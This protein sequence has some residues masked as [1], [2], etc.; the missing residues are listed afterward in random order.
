MSNDQTSTHLLKD[1]LLYIYEKIEKNK[2][3]NSFLDALHVLLVW[4]IVFIL[5]EH[6]GY[7]PI[8]IKRGS[9]I[10][11]IVL[12]G[13]VYWKRRQDVE[14]SNFIDFYRTFSSVS[15]LKELGYA[16][17]L[18][19]NTV[20]HPKLIEAAIFKNLELVKL[21]KFNSKLDEFY[22]SNPYTKSLAKKKVFLLLLMGVAVLI[23]LNLNDATTRYFTFYQDF[24]K[25]NPYSF[26]ITPGNSTLEQG[27]PFKVTIEF[28]NDLIPNEVSLFLKTS[29]EQEFRKRGLDGQSNIFISSTIDLNT[30]ILYYLEMDGFKTEVFEVNIQLRPRLTEFNLTIIPPRYTRLD[31]SFYKYP[32][33]QVQGIQGSEMLLFG[34]ANKP[35]K[36][37]V[38]KNKEYK[39]D[40]FI[41]D[42]LEFSFVSSLIE[43]DTVQ[44]KLEDEAGL[45]NLNP[46]Q[47][48]VFPIKDEHPIAEILEPK[49]SFEKI[50]PKTITIRYRTSD[51]FGITKTTLVYELK[52]AFIEQ[53]VSNTIEF[54]SNKNGILQTFS[55]DI[56]SLKLKPKDELIF[57]IETTDNDGFNGYK[58]ARSVSITLSV[59]SLVDYFD[60]IN[61]QEEQIQ[62]DLENVSESFE[63]M[64]K[65]YEMFEEQMRV[66]PVVDYKDI[67]QLEEVKERQE[68][69]KEQLEKLNAKFEE[70]KEE[71]QESN[72]LSEE[73]LE[74]Y[75]ELQKLLDEIDDPAF[76]DALQEL[77]ENL[78]S[79][80]LEQ[81]RQAMQ[82]TEFNEQ[83][84][85]E[86]IER[87]VELFKKLKLNADLE[88][89]ATS[90]ED[91]ARQE[92]KQRINEEESS[93]EK[94]EDESL[95]EQTK[96]VEKN[97]EKLDENTSLNTKSIIDELQ[98]QSKKKLDDIKKALEKRLEEMNNE[99][100]DSDSSNQK[101]DDKNNGGK[102]GDK[103]KDSGPQ[104]QQEP[105]LKEQFQ[106]LAQITRNAMSQM[107]QEQ[108]NVNIAGLQYILFSLLNLSLEQEE[109]SIYTSSTKSRSKAY[110]E[111]AR[112]QKNVENIFLSLSDSLF[113]LSKDIPPFSNQI[114]EDK[115]EVERLVEESLTQI[116]ERNQNRASVATRQALGG[117]NKIS[118][119]IAG[120]LEQLQNQNSGQGGSG[121]GMSMQQMI[122][123]MQQMGKNQQQINQQIQ[124][125][126]NDIQGERLSQDQMERLDQLSQQQNK[127]R[128][129]LQDIQQN[130][131]GVDGDKLGSELERMIEQME[132]TINDLR[133]GAVD[134]TLIWRQQNILSRM[135]E[136]ENALQERDVEEKRKGTS[137]EQINR[138]TPPVITLEELEQQI[139]NKLNDPNFTK[140]SPDYQRLIE[141]Y[142]EL[143][144]EIQER[145]IQ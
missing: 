50:E 97:L 30:D 70:L 45:K 121:S 141:R 93:A 125:T 26:N 73:T 74:A 57:W 37:F 118:Y 89:L 40:L 2:S 25:P 67:R 27:S 58:T 41:D 51:D 80:T 11:G 48:L 4:S 108:M 16:L 88:K 106:R 60:E 68:Q 6:V 15:S 46:F 91:M 63:E 133:G 127:I 75:N 90:Y 92:E 62:S 137:G 33:S 76:R 61:D 17:D 42:H 31:S 78:N 77:Q 98:E 65:Q 53:M 34:K 143:L 99:Q 128:K 82:K 38:I 140:Y 144:K 86:R 66:N 111:Y 107:N 123:Q 122:E 54:A 96:Q 72:V 120:L 10:G 81:M 135:L 52:R 114:N 104:P 131:S 145:E 22:H 134:P 112:N 14:S 21:E 117:I 119:K 43:L 29:I 59:P 35:L 9:I 85:K 44:F 7:L 36:E 69:V 116:A 113:K 126:I 19:R 5:I 105:S 20:A 12:C 101:N 115:L 32:F 23:S 138:V 94:N 129:Q 139:R 87:T 132:E 39:Q 124:D 18:E 84:Y 109:L 47:F 28:T 83:L 3:Y 64:Q 24:E 130:G 55:F 102:Q 49:S 79:M 103:N 8:E 95:L 56:D 1:R 142:F 110:V 100:S 71:L 13:L 136:A